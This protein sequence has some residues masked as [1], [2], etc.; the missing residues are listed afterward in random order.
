MKSVL[1]SIR[2]E[3]CGK[4]VNGEKTIELRKTRPKIDTPFKCYIYCTLGK[5]DLFYNPNTDLSAKEYIDTGIILNGKVIGEFMCNLID[6]VY[7]CHSGYVSKYGCISRPMFFNYLGLPF[8][9]HFGYDKY[10]YAWR[11]SDLIIYDEPK[12][13]SEFGIKRPPQSWQYIDEVRL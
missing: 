4:I 3:W 2:P 8:E 1:I 12:E 7:Q 10:A 11:I 13:L 5:Y 9:T 6:I